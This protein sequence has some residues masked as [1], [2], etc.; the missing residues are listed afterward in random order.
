MNIVD[1]L[2]IG[3]I[4]LGGLQ[5]YHKGLI[6]GIANLF[7]S[8]AGL[9]I[10]AYE[11]VNLLVWA[12]QRFGLQAWLEPIVYKII[13]PVIEAQVKGVDGKISDAITKMFPTEISSVIGT[14]GANGLSSITQNALQQIGNKIAG[15]ITENILRLLAFAVIFFAVVF[16]VQVMV[17][18]LLAP[19]GLFGGTVNKGGGFLLG[20]V[21]YFLGLTVLAGVAS[22]FVQM[23]TAGMFSNLVQNSM[24]YPTLTQSFQM[25]SQLLAV[26]FTSQI[27]QQFPSGG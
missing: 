5:G 14:N 22:P 13:K 9:V 12:E 27:W 3:L 10:A 23:G 16:L 6:T 8:I 19:M 11:Y 1:V 17:K 25:I 24:L 18:I 4:L 26:N 2:I 21:S 15:G 20:V 7:G